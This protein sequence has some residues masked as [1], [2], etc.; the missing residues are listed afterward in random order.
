MVVGSPGCSKPAVPADVFDRGWVAGFVGL[1]ALWPYFVS[2]RLE[3]RG[4]YRK[5]NAI[6]EQLSKGVALHPPRQNC[7]CAD[8]EEALG[9]ETAGSQSV[10]PRPDIET[11]SDSGASQCAP[12][13]RRHC[14]WAPLESSS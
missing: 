14:N 7:L 6:W 3:W 12:K 9:P 2:G 10:C 8:V 5:S 11:S 13:R 1:W 4:R